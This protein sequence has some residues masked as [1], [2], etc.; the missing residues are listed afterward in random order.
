M[1]ATPSSKYIWPNRAQSLPVAWQNDEP[2]NVPLSSVCAGQVGTT[3]N[4]VVGTDAK[5]APP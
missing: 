4:T 2:T 1:G 3:A 5:D